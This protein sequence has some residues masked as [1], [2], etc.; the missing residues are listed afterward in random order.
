MQLCQFIAYFINILFSAI[1][2]KD[3]CKISNFLL[4]FLS[5]LA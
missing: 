4:T 2:I 3:I 5:R 1:K